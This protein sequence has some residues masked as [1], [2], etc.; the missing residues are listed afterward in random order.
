MQAIQ[1]LDWLFDH[2]A[3]FVA[4]IVNE[5]TAGKSLGLCLTSEAGPARLYL[6]VRVDTERQMQMKGFIKALT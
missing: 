5:L 1:T 6:D 2:K 3:S 4:S